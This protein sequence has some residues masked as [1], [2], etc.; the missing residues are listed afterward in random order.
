MTHCITTATC[1][2]RSGPEHDRRSSRSRA[3]L[4][5]R[6]RRTRVRT[7]NATGRVLGLC[8]G[9]LL[10]ASCYPGPVDPVGIP[11]A[12]SPFVRAPY[13]QAVSDSAAWVMWLTS[14]AT[15]DTVWYRLPALDTT[16]IRSEVEPHRGGTRRARLAPLPAGSTVEYRVSAAG[17]RMGPHAFRT[18]LSQVDPAEEPPEIRVLLFGDSGWGGPEQIALAREMHRLEWDL[19]IHVGDIAYDDGTEREFS[20]R[21]FRVYAPMLAEVP[22]FPAVGNH[23]VRAD[24]GASYDAAFLWPAPYDGARHYSFRRGSTF[25]VSVD[26]ASPTPDAEGLR[27]SSGAQFEWLDATLSAAAADTSVRWIIAFEHHPVYSHAVG[28]SGHGLDRALSRHLTPLYERYGVDL[29][30]AGH[31]HHYERT[32]PVRDGRAVEPG[33][34]T[35]HVVSGGG[36]ASLYARDV[37]S[38]S[39]TARA[40]RAYHF[41]ELRI[42]SSSIHAR[43][44]GRDGATLDQFELEPYLGTAAGLADRCER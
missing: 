31:D 15:P 36:G 37:G 17:V 27:S 18:P 7:A 10:F 8:L 3:F 22:L 20:E 32:R 28:I 39:L 25:F 13:L 11:V 4:A 40:R 21:H 23:D 44:I 35:V 24:R 34:G 19:A 2:A 16:W 12:P 38:S 6:T 5:Y 9:G 26:T 43:V 33:C 1:T 14:P 30:A 42:G 41:V 29:V